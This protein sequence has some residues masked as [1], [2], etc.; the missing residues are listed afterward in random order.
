MVGAA[1]IVNMIL[2]INGTSLFDKNGDPYIDETMLDYTSL[3]ADMSKN[4]GMFGFTRT[5]CYI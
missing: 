2:Q 5:E 3:L 1:N 4:I